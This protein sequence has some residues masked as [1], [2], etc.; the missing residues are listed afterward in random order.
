[1]EGIGRKWGKRLAGDLAQL[2]LAALLISL[3][4]LVLPLPVHERL[5]A[6]LAL[7]DLDAPS[8]EGTAL[9][10]QGARAVVLVSHG[11][12]RHVLEEAVEHGILVEAGRPLQREGEGRRVVVGHDVDRA[13]SRVAGQVRREGLRDQQVAHDLRGK[14]IELD[15]LPVR[16]RARH[17]GRVVQGAAV[18]IL[19]ATDDRELP[20][21]DV[22]A[23]YAL[24]RIADVGGGE[25]REILRAHHVHE[26]IRVHAQL[27]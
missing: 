26:L 8:E 21:H 6:E 7:G 24:Q 3:P 13:G 4:G 27:E 10:A 1:M 22:D 23:G 12:V 17:C 14:E 19:E 2:R 15:G 20:L 5:V 16:I 11:R 9:G 25:L 18:A